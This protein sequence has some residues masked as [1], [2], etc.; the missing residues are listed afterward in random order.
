MVSHHY[1]ANGLWPIG[2]YLQ[3]YKMVALR[4]R[5]AYGHIHSVVSINASKLY[6]DSFIRQSGCAR[7]FSYWGLLFTLAICPIK[8]AV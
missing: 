3:C 2:E 1:I 6:L 4:L 8:L 5:A 7:V